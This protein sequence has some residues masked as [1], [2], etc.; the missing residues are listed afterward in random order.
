MKKNQNPLSKIFRWIMIFEAFFNIIK[1][2]L[3]FKNISI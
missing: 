2:F 1:I 3:A